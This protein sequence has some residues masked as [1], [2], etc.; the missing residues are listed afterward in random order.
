ML[1][2]T[3]HAI[4]DYS[5]HETATQASELRLAFRLFG[6]SNCDGVLLQWRSTTV[7]F[8]PSDTDWTAACPPRAG[9]RACS[10]RKLLLV[11]P[12]TTLM[13]EEGTQLHWLTS[14][15][16]ACMTGGPN[17]WVAHLSCSQRQVWLRR[18]GVVVIKLLGLVRVD[19][20]H[21]STTL[22]IFQ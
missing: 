8:W 16:F 20:T 10:E 5:T 4:L 2:G 13:G 17:R 1:T 11:L 6:K 9:G 14:P 18:E 22:D 7:C 3:V 15:A 19:V 12:A 21:Q